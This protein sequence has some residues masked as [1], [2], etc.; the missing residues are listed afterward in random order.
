[1]PGNT[2]REKLTAVAQ[3]AIQQPGRTLLVVHYAGHGC[4]NGTGQL[5]ISDRLGK[6]LARANLLI[7]PFDVTELSLSALIDVLYIFNR[8]FGYLRSHGHSNST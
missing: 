8:C 1:M 7:T 3:A 6:K 5:V 2:I 4:D